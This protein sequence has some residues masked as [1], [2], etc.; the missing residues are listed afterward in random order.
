V[1]HR[2][3]EPLRRAPRDDPQIVPADVRVVQ[4]KELDRQ[5]VELDPVADVREVAPAVGLQVG[6]EIAWAS[7]PRAPRPPVGA[8]HQVPE[9]VQQARGVVVVR[10][11]NE[12]RR[13]PSP[14][15]ADRLDRRLD[16]LRL[17]QEVARDDGHVR[18]GK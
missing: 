7:A 2:E 5:A 16:C 17:G 18:F 6:D 1:H 11:E 8:R 4:A 10:A 9:R 13:E 12:P 3:P 15:R 14:V